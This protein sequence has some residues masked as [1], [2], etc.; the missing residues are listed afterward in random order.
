M[1]E[2]GT[3]KIYVERYKGP[4]ILAIFQCNVSEIISH[5]QTESQKGKIALN[6]SDNAFYRMSEIAMGQTE[7][8]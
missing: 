3:F 7:T 5:S 4:I 1:S 8:F 2:H 6:I